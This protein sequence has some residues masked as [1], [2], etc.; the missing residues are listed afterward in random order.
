MIRAVKREEGSI[1]LLF[2]MFAFIIS[3]FMAFSFYVGGS[4]TQQI[5]AQNAAEASAK[6][7]AMY[8][9]QGM[10]L[11]SVNNQGIAASLHIH[12]SLLSLTYYLG[13]VRV[14][15][16]ND[17]ELTRV[18]ANDRDNAIQ[19][20]FDI[21][22]PA[23][24]IFMRTANGFSKYNDMIQK[25]WVSLTPLRGVELARMNSP[26][27]VVFPYQG[28]SSSVSSYV[29][30]L[31]K[32]DNSV[33][34]KSSPSVSLCHTVKNYTDDDDQIQDRDNQLLWVLGPLV[35]TDNAGSAAGTVATL[36][37][38]FNALKRYVLPV[39][40]GMHTEDCGP[41]LR[42]NLGDIIGGMAP[43]IHALM[44]MADALC[45]MAEL[46]HISKLND[47]CDVLDD[48][49]SS[50]S[51]SSPDV[52]MDWKKQANHWKTSKSAEEFGFTYIDSDAAF[53][54]LRDNLT[55]RVRVGAPWF[56]AKEQKDIDCAKY[57][58]SDPDSGNSL[59]R[60]EMLTRLGSYLNRDVPE[61]HA[62][63]GGA[64]VLNEEN[65][66]ARMQW[67]IAR[68]KVD[69]MPVPGDDPESIPSRM[70]TFWPAWSAYP[71]PTKLSQYL[72]SDVGMAV[73]D[74]L[75]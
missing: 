51:D 5:K 75:L 1:T 66:W 3:G 30:F 20:L 38:I 61:V 39:N 13:F 60:M 14:F 18:L 40:F 6:A 67:S 15:T 7:M 56:T 43:S 35:A 24:G 57:S 31:F 32:T 26:G 37:S 68:W 54:K 25:F 63:Q 29:P 52:L 50:F 21:I 64:E 11:M 62:L 55:V 17:Y 4:V 16:L 41:V 59:C 70:K 12:N 44:G 28:A 65:T 8:A 2:A 74:S 72:S 71:T 23:G 45:S 46:L 49:S 33:Y 53:E 34:K 22:Q 9:A 73:L 47:V 27:A 58:E 48:I 19:K 42:S 36:A 69:W 10:N